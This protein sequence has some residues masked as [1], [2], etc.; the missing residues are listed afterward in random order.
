MLFL[1][2]FHDEVKHRLK[3][4]YNIDNPDDD[5]ITTI[6][7]FLCYKSEEIINANIIDEIIKKYL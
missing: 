1:N 6:V 3:E 2:F 4:V 7:Y 5:L